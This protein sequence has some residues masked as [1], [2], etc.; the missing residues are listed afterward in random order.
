MPSECP[1]PPCPSAEEGDPRR[2]AQG[3]AQSRHRQQPVHRARTAGLSWLA[4]MSLP[5]QAPHYQ[6]RATGMCSA[7][8]VPSLE[9]LHWAAEALGA[10]Q[11][12]AAC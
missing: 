3:G 6:L 5:L 10:S 2:A 7:S 8:P 11:K 12:S 4:S 1:R 9:A